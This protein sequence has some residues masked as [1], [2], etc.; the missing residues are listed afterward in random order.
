MHLKRNIF[1]ALETPFSPQWQAACYGVKR[2][3]SFDHRPPDG[4]VERM[5]PSASFQYALNF[6]AH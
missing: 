4:H 5:L 2:T 1:V 6:L 3:G